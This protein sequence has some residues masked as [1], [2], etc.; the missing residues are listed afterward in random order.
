VKYLILVFMLFITVPAVSQYSVFVADTSSVSDTDTLTGQWIDLGQPQ[1]VEGRI[2]LFV[3][4]DKISGTQTKSIQVEVQT[5]GGRGAILNNKI[6]SQWQFADS[7]ATTY[8]DLTF[9]D[10]GTTLNGYWIDLADKLS[11]WNKFHSIRFRFFAVGGTHKTRIYA[12]AEI[13]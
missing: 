1:N 3:A 13:N 6:G 12:L 11:V 10:D 5:R 9:S 8:L 2:S 4:G 7:V